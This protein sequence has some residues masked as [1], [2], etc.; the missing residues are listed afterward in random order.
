LKS[1]GS[2]LS[3][4]PHFV[5]VKFSDNWNGEGEISFSPALSDEISDEKICSSMI[6]PL[7][8]YPHHL[9]T[10]SICAENTNKYKMP[11]LLTEDLEMTY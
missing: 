2:R 4:R 8:P 9:L 11:Y 3:L 5:F 1:C 10:I 7:L 6:S